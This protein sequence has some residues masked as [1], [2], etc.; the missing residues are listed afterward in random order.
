MF[1]FKC[2]E[3]PHAPCGCNNSKQFLEKRLTK[4]SP[5]AKFLR[6][7]ND[8]IKPCPNPECQIRKYSS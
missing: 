4:H 7:A 3:A 1:C 6:N 8:S 2:G 5:E